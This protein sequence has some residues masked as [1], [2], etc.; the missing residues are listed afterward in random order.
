MPA[1]V[2]GSIVADL[3]YCSGSVQLANLSHTLAGGVMF[4]L[5]IG[6]L[7][8]GLAYAARTV[9]LGKLARDWQPAILQI[10]WPP[11]GPLWVVLL[12]LLVGAWTHVLLDSFTHKDG[13]LAEHLTALQVSLGTVAGRKVRICAVLWYLCSF[14]GVA[15][16]FRAFWR[17]QAGSG[18][19]APPNAREPGWLGSFLFA[20]AVFPIEVVHHLF[21]NGFGIAMVVVLTLLLVLLVSRTLSRDQ[22]TN[23]EDEQSVSTPTAWRRVNHNR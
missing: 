21:E 1:L 22:I 19:C 23:P 13:W 8:L 9:V 3:S 20:S 6:L 10:P 5:P 12:S 2:V 15:L 17:R 18:A 11:L 14:L 7:V 16:V 4:C